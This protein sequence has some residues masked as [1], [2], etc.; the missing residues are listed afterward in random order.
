MPFGLLSSLKSLEYKLRSTTLHTIVEGGGDMES[1]EHTANH[2]HCANEYVLQKEMRK[3]WEE[4][5]YWMKRFVDVAEDPE[6]SDRV[7]NEL[8]RNTQVMMVLFAQC[9]GKNAVVTLE[10]LLRMHLTI[11]VAYILAKMRGDTENAEEL[12]QRWSENAE[13]IAILSANLNPF[14]SY[15]LLQGMWNEHLENLKDEIGNSID[16]V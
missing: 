3:L 7:Q 4:Q 1:F 10:D 9:F 5:E 6:N 13:Q 12:S 15:D 16:Q 8:L 14:F 2:T 11:G